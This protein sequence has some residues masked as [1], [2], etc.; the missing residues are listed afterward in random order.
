MFITFEGLDGSGKSTQV[1]FLVDALRAGGRQVLAVREPGGTDLGE[2]IRDLV[3]HGGP[4][5][6]VAEMLLYM[7]ARAQLL[8]E[9][10]EPA[11]AAGG[12]VIADRYHDSTRAY[13]GGGRGLEVPWP[14]DF[15]VPDRTYLVAVP[16]ATAISRRAGRS[17][18]R[19]ER[20]PDSFHAAVAAE[21]DRLA[22]AEPRRWLR[23]DGTRPPQILSRQVAS[24]ALELLG[25]QL[26]S[27]S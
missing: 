27:S 5:A 26:Q 8:A 3:L 17:A 6:P 23:L 10:V 20:E 16:A 11:L 4:V 18:D 14:R 21:Y 15:R 13:Q 24:D 7:T 9:V 19:L 12:V 25:R 22:A 1:E 2:R